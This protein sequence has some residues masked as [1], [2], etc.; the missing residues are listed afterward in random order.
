MSY[1][2]AGTRSIVDLFAGDG[3]PGR[4]D[5]DAIES[6]ERQFNVLEFCE[7]ADALGVDRRELFSRTV[8]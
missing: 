1:M 6:G 4:V 5:A 8:E 2:T 7:L 3:D